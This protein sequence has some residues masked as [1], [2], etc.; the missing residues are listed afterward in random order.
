MNNWTQ[1]TIVDLLSEDGVFV[2]GD[3]IEKKD[4]D[5]SG[6]VRL[7]QL[8]DIG[9]GIF[10][11]KSDRFLTKDKAQE[12]GCTFLKKGDVLI[13]RLGE[14][15][16]KACIF[17]LEGEEKYVTAVDICIFR[18]KKT[19]NKWL[20]HW[21]NSPQFKRLVDQYKT[22]TTRKRI[23][24]KNLA[25]VTFPTPKIDEQKQIVDKI[26]ELFSIS[27]NTEDELKKILAKL[28]LY[29][30]SI[31]ENAYQGHLSATWRK[32]NPQKDVVSLLKS[33]SKVKEL[34][35]IQANV[36]DTWRVTR[37]GHV[38]NVYVG[39]TPSRKVEEY[40][41]GD[42]KW[43]S[44]GEVSFCRISDTKEKITEE[45]LGNTSTTVHPPGTVLL[46]MIGE[47]KTRGQAAI[48]EI[49]ASHNQN[50]AAIRVSE[51]EILPEY[52]YYYLMSQYERTRMVGSGNNQKAL[53]KSR[54]QE[55]QIPIAPIDEQKFIVDKL[56][57][58]L[59]NINSTE[60]VIVSEITKIHSL[61]QSILSKA[62]SGNLVN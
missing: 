11:D 51:T 17:P 47:G 50:S 49:D 43:V 25:K 52:V 40:W 26:E 22:G 2:D 56:S 61:K 19:D 5:P 20:M 57:E 42:I 14:P 33:I 10:K 60:A 6:K 8:A 32:E 36:P 16:A 46:G 23:S 15:L 34:E 58:I 48:L 27:T 55:L 38:F 41:N 39:A 29:R 31:L 7:I 53:N 18:S 54:V 24:R 3:W 28:K 21:I 4:Q 35:A 30:R 59:S 44:S 1:Q 37:I 45:G 13:S 12:L 9:E 62:F